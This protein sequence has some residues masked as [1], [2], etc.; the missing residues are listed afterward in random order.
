MVTVRHGVRLVGLLAAGLLLSTFAGSAASAG[1][2]AASVAATSQRATHAAPRSRRGE[3][4][5]AVTYGVDQLQVRSVSSG[6]SLEFRYRVLDPGKASVLNDQ[7]AT[8]YLID[9]KSGTRLTV[10]TMEKVGTLRQV[11][12]PEPGREYWMLFANTGKVVK[13]G[14]RVDIVIG[15]FHA[16]SLLVE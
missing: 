15:A 13:P 9:Q 6:A 7:R 3:A 5:Y 12:D 10:P 11:A 14:Q 2:G 16:S 1:D 8:P 4:Y